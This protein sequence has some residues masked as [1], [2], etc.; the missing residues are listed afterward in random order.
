[1]P[2]RLATFLLALAMGFGGLGVGAAGVQ[3]KTSPTVTQGVTLTVAPQNSQG[4]VKPGED[5]VVNGDLSNGTSNAVAAGTASVYLTRSVSGSREDLAA[6]LG[7]DAGTNAPKLGT[8][9]LQ[10]A[11]PAMPAGASQSLS[12]VVPAGAIGIGS[13][14][15]TFGARQLAVV[16][17]SGG[18][19]V[20][21]AYSSIVWS[22]G[23]SFQPTKLAFVMP[24]TLPE[25][26]VGLIPSAALATYTAP[27]GIL[28]HE[29]TQALNQPVA[30]G[31]DPMIIASIRILGNTAPPTALDWLDR[32]DKAPNQTFALSYA[33]SDISALSQAGGDPALAPI[34]FTIDPNLF[35]VVPSTPTTTPS[36]TPTD[37]TSPTSTPTT[38]VPPEDTVPTSENLADFDYTV[39]S[40]AWPREGT[41]VSKDLDTFATRGL[42]T[43]ILSS[44][45]ATYG[46][47]GYT[48][49]AS[50]TVDKHPALIADATISA[51][52]RKAVLAPTTLEW[53]EAMAELSSSLAVVTRER[54]GESRTML[55]SLGRGYPTSSFRLAT[56]LDALANVPWFSPATLTDAAATPPVAASMVDQPQQAERITQVG[57]LLQAETTVT[58][59]ASVLTD[60][61]QLTGPRRLSL[62]ATLSAAWVGNPTGWSGYTQFLSA[63]NN[64]L[65]A[66]TLANGGS[67]FQPADTIPLPVTVRNDLD[68]PV[69]VVIQVRSPSGVLDVVDKQVPLTVE[70]HSQARASVAVRSLANGDVTLS[71]GL[72]SPSGVKIGNS[73]TADVRVQAGWETAIT[74]VFAILLVAIFGFG[75]YRNI[76]KRRKASKARRAGEGGAESPDEP[77]AVLPDKTAD[78]PAS[79]DDTDLRE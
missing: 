4:I 79:A 73:T 33:D 64:T 23:V 43:S 75:I 66:V 27:G 76:S 21:R 7:A 49:S 68:F 9:V 47:V 44:T 41:V 65:R 10:V 26:T 13:E 59:F 72:T 12:L 36:D 30:I 8:E 61:T 15:S 34:G 1:M 22:P 32:L 5:L 28:N 77:G 17:S 39:K 48:P 2:M 16:V 55:A 45:N 14:S 56:T 57:R 74:V 60:P 62:L 20:A 37:P 46:K 54:P 19:T 18:S 78:T 35:P 51:L 25:S 70:A 3:A 67:I 52:F 58:S 50:V 11:T 63:S 31:V 40:L 6:W 71:V 24:I 42:T 69:N 29:L 38:T 53:Q